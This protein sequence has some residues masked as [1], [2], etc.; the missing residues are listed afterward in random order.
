MACYAARTGERRVYFTTQ[1]AVAYERAYE[2]YPV[3]P[4]GLPESA[5]MDG[6]RDAKAAAGPDRRRTTCAG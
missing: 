6:Y 5:A 4:W 2:A 1:Q 3:A